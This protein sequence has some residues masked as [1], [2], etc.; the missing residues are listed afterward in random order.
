MS[1]KRRS[2]RQERFVPPDVVEEQL[3]S[4]EAAVAAKTHRRPESRGTERF[5]VS[6][7][8]L[9][10]RIGT[11]R[12]HSADDY[13]HSIGYRIRL[14]NVI[15]EVHAL[16]LTEA[17]AWGVAVTDE[18]DQL[19]LSRSS[20]DVDE[21]ILSPHRLVPEYWFLRRVPDDEN[22]VAHLRMIQPKKTKQDPA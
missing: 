4:A 2:V 20:P 13:L 11:N 3:A 8:S 10:D 18:I 6:W 21:L 5:L 14:Q 9:V 1:R 16:D 17:S 7:A 19:F 22:V 12:P 15:D